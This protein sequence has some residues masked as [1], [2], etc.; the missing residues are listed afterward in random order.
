[1]EDRRKLKRR[2]LL[3]YSRVFDMK[4][5][6]LIGYLSNITPEGASL[7][8]DEPVTT[9]TTYRLRMDLPEEGFNRDHLMFDA[10][11]VYCKPDVDPNFFVTGFQLQGVPNE[12]IDI[13]QRIVQ[14]Y[15]FRD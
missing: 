13:I 2:Y 3:F 8:C 10:K 14:E 9:D 12:D 15:G 6:R 7:I 11:A 1:M 4:S 5:G